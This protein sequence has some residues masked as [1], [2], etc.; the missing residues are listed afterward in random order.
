MTASTSSLGLRRCRSTAVEVPTGGEA[1]N[2]RKRRRRI[3]KKRRYIPRESRLYETHINQLAGTSSSQL[4]LPR[5]AALGPVLLKGWVDT[6]GP[7]RSGRPQNTRAARLLPWRKEILRLLHINQEKRLKQERGLFSA[8]K[9]QQATHRQQ[10]AVR[11]NSEE[12]S[13]DERQSRKTR[14]SL[15]L[16]GPGLAPLPRLGLL[17]GLGRA[18]H[19]RGDA[20]ARHECSTPGG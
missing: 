10:P 1:P 19:G 16:W 12:L 2:P 4:N 5:G 9:I 18:D 11:K 17:G 3:D 8:E 20:S 15:V 7:I 14:S 6:R 13:S